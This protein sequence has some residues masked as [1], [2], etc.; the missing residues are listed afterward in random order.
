MMI[1]NA[2][3]NQPEQR[4]L[5]PQSIP[6]QVFLNHFFALY[7]YIEHDPRAYYVSDLPYFQSFNPTLSDEV[8]ASAKRH[9]LNSWNTEYTLRST[10]EQGSD[11]YLR[12]S[13]HWTYPQAY[14]AVQ[15]SLI[16]MLR[17]HDNTTRRP[18]WVTQAGSR[19]IVRGGYPRAASFYATG[20]PQRPQLRRLPFGQTNPG[21]QLTQSVQEAQQQIGQFLRTTHRQRGQQLRTVVQN[22]P[23][24]AL[25]SE[26]TGKILRRFDDAQWVKLGQ[27]VGATTIFH[28]LSRLRVSDSH[29]EIERFIDADIDVALFH[30]SLLGIVHYLNFVHEAYVVKAMGVEA[31][32]QWLETLPDYLQDSFIEERFEA[33]TR[34]LE[35]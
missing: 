5:S 33:M 3:M 26:R 27:Q 4:T 11:E 29:R 24:L 8:I 14:Y 28:L 31:Y 20:N 32:G 1:E 18:E 9:L 6:A 16:A 15:E 7:Y 35:F 22:D 17:L 2:V 21:L 19:L 25:R 30:E 12:H 10:A 34:R 13:L 23:E